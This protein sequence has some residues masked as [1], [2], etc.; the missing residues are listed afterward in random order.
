MSPSGGQGKQV[1]LPEANRIAL[2][3][4][5]AAQEHS[6]CFGQVVD[7]QTSEGENPG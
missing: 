4:V 5:E 7:I 6:Y 3:G 2:L 1:G